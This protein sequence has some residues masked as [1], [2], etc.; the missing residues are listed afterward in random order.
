MKVH[1]VYCHPSP[2]SY[3]HEVFTSLREQLQ[4][5]GFD[6]SFSDLYAEN[7]RSDMTEEE[8]ARE[9][10][11]ATQ[12]DLAEDVL[13]EQARLAVAVCVVF[14]YPVWWSDCPAKL[15]GWFDRVFVRGY[16]YGAVDGVTSMPVIPY[17]LV[18]CTAGHP[19]AVLEATGIDSSMRTVMLD[20]R[21][22]KR[23][24]A[25]DMI[26]LSG[27][28]TPDRARKAHQAIIAGIPQQIGRAIRDNRLCEPD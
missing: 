14:L 2:A 21:L 28:L 15:K 12:V 19:A 16:A 23:F 22:A 25:K 7:F 24:L 17:G 13:R 26:V 4:G 11:N 20:D 10:G 9:G 6:C 1:I 8:Y 18:V 27:T 5:A 3:T